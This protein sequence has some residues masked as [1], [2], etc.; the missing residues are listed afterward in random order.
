MSTKTAKTTKK[1][2]AK[3]TAKK[4]VTKKVAAKKT[5]AK[6]K[7]PAKA[8]KAKKEAVVKAVKFSPN[9]DLHVME[10]GQ[11]FAD[12]RA[13]GLKPAD[14]ISKYAEAGIK[15]NLQGYYG[16]IRLSKAP[17]AVHDALANNEVRV[18][19]VMGILGK[20]ATAEQIEADLKALIESRKSR[21]KFL[22]KGGFEG[23]KNI[24]KARTVALVKEKLEKLKATKTLS[25][26]RGKVVL[27]FIEELMAANNEDSIQ[28]LLSSFE[29]TAAKK[30]AKKATAAA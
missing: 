6:K 1:V 17:K 29:K 10:R 3:K 26:G 24:T 15:V 9:P 8:T 19:E 16:A 2:A 11:E 25:E 18:T 22:K 23:G 12:L 13:Q 4:T 20:Y 7:A 21:V 28:K 27:A 14:I 5:V 30:K